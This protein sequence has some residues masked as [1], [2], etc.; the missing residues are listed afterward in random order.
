MSE[1]DKTGPVVPRGD[2]GKWLPGASPN[3]GG[4]PRRLVEVEA[5]LD[6]EFRDVAS[7]REAFTV[8]RK[9]ALQGA[10]NDVFDK[11]G[12]VCGEKTT[13][14]PAYMQMLF[15]RLLGPVKDLDVDLTGVSPEALSELRSVLKQ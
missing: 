8:L 1:R 11:E 6:A 7:I 10:T 2:A 3:P 4:R 9:L 13:Y 5:M 12:N 14:H 15:D